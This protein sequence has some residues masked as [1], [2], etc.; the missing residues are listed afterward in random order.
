MCYRGIRVPAGVP[1][2]QSTYGVSRDKMFYEPADGAL[3]T[4]NRW[5]SSRYLPSVTKLFATGR[6]ALGWEVDLL[7]DVHHRLSPIEAARLG[8][9][10]EPF[11]LFWLDD[12]VAADT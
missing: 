5:S 9:D 11:R 7:H 2:L 10:L 6:E 4:E 1:R 8:R 3:P 12:S